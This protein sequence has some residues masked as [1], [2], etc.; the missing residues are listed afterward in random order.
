MTVVAGFEFPDGLHYQA[1]DQVW[2]RLVGDGTATVGITAFGVHQAGGEIFMCRPKTVG[3]LAL[4]RRSVAVVEVAK[5]I[6]AVKSPVSGRV[7]AVNET[8]GTQPELVHR[9][10][11]G[12]GWIARLELAD[13]AAD[14]MALVSGDAVAPAM[15]HQAWLFGQAESS[16]LPPAEA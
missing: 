12:A 9:D 13:F 2:A 1:E 5:A 7:V 11:Y 16:A 10:P 8:L 14:A 6:V 3:S 15:Q 4:Q